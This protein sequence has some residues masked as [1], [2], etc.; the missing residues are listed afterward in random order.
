MVKSSRESGNKS[1]GP[2][3]KE[4]H[5][6]KKIVGEPILGE[7]VWEESSE[8]IPNNKIAFEMMGKNS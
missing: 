4:I 5:I 7:V 8:S 1:Q 2:S 3:E 6:C